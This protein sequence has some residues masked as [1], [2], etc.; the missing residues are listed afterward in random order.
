MSTVS[1]HKKSQREYKPRRPERTPL[2]Q[3]IKKHFN[4]WFNNSKNPVPGYVSKEFK[5]YL[6]CGILAKGFACAH[7]DSCQ[8]DFLIV[9]LQRKGSMSFLQYT[10]Y[11][12]NGSTFN[13]KCYSTSSHQAVCDQLSSKNSPLSSDAYMSSRC[14]SYCDRRDSE[15]AYRLRS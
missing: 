8:K 5:S 11:G 15:K 13:R 4:T 10:R 14:S 3:V 1:C 12:G 2:F 7:C 6:G 9:F